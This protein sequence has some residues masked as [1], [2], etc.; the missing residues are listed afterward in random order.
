MHCPPPGFALL[1]CLTNS[2][3]LET[4]IVKVKFIALFQRYA[5]IAF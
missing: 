5:D 3:D 4:F 1:P 2:Q